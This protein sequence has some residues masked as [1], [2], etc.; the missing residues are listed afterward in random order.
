MNDDVES[1]KKEL[2]ERLESDLYVDRYSSFRESVELIN[3][4]LESFNINYQYTYNEFCSDF[5]NECLKYIDEHPKVDM[6]DPQQMMVYTFPIVMSI[7]DRAKNKYGIK[8]DKS[9]STPIE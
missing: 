5:T 1:K 4:A 8:D 2:K 9:N 6:T 3:K 7:V